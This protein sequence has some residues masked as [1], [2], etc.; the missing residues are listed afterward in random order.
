MLQLL[1]DS[2]KEFTNHV[3]FQKETNLVNVITSENIIRY[4][5]VHDGNEFMEYPPYIIMEYTNNGT[6]R[7]LIDGQNGE[8]FDIEILKSIYL[9]LARGMKC[10]NEYLVHR[11]EVYPL[12]RTTL[13]FRGVI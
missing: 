7:D 10:I 9:Q 2:F 6:L 12:S 3:S 8:Q 5:Y 13:N 4:L 11:D 1:I